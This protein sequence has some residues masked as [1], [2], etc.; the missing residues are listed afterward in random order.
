MVKARQFVLCFWIFNRA[1]HSFDLAWLI[2][3]VDVARY[4]KGEIAGL[5]LA[6]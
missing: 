4:E 2:I 5:R 6:Q 3:T 1:R